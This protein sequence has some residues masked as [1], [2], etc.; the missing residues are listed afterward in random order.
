MPA[1]LGFGF[2]CNCFF[3]WFCVA[4]LVFVVEVSLLVCWLLLL[5][6]FA[7]WVGGF[8]WLSLD[9]MFLDCLFCY[10]GRLV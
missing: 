7:L 4:G 8:A 1:G 5:W 6:W 2:T 3:I 10:V 9:S